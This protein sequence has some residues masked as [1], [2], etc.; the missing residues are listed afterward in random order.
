[1]R[2]IAVCAEEQGCPLYKKDSKLDFTPPTV[3]GL[4]GMPICSTAMEHLQR[5][6]SKIQAGLSAGGFA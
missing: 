1:M 3:A 2:V 5:S 6:V 4:D